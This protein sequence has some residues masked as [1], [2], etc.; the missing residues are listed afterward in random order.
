MGTTVPQDATN[1]WSVTSNGATVVL[2]GSACTTWRMPSNT[3][4][5]FNFPCDALH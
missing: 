5:A 4:I 3:S 1:G 2:N